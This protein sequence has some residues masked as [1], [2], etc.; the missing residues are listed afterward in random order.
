MARTARRRSAEPGDFRIARVVMLR[1]ARNRSISA[2]D[3]ALGPRHPWIKRILLLIVAAILV[4]CA[5]IAMLIVRQ[6]ERDEAQRADAI[7]VFGAAEYVGK[8]SPV[9]RARLDH[10]YELYHQGL[11]PIVITTGG[12]GND[13]RHTEG[14]VGVAYLER[15]GIPTD[16]LLA[17][18][19]AH[20]TGAS[21]ERVAE[22]MRAH[23]MK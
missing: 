23:G 4:Y 6:S 14:G 18:T 9:F 8:P 19:E 1:R 12:A 7:V 16:R 22:I 15:R 21:A 20:N 3:A 17:E 13:L 11:A 5:A 2:T 10:G